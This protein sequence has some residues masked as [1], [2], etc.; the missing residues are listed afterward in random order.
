M[1]LP[2][3]DLVNPQKSKQ[4]KSRDRR[5]RP[6][7]CYTTVSRMVNFD[8]LV[9]A[10]PLAKCF[11]IQTSIAQRRLIIIYYSPSGNTHSKLGTIQTHQDRQSQFEGFVVTE[12]HFWDPVLTERYLQTPVV[13]QHGYW[14]LPKYRR[15]REYLITNTTFRK[16]QGTY[17]IH[18]LYLLFSTCQLLL[19][20]RYK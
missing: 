16:G 12:S 7:G 2:Q 1:F 19:V 15:S 8:E 9:E 11:F 6:L 3:S 10:R 13:T 4:N 14:D 20:L 17:E 18:Q 5:I